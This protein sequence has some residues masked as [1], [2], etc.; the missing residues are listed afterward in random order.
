VVAAEALTCCVVVD[1]P[2]L[3]AT[4][5]AVND[6]RVAGVIVRLGHT[7]RAKDVVGREVARF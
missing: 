2:L 1:A 7:A 4:R 5:R 6:A 3:T